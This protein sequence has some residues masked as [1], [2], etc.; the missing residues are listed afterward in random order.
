MNNPKKVIIIGGI[1]NAVNVA[2]QMV[3]SQIRFGTKDEFLGFAFDDET[4][5]PEINGFP[6]LGKSRSIF[7]K[8]EKYSDVYFLYQMYRP[9]RIKERA[10]WIPEFNI[11]TE[12]FYNF[13]HPLATICRSVKMGYG[14]IIHAGCVLNVNVILGNHN[15]INSTCLVAHDTELGN[16]N[17]LAA[18]SVIGSNVKIKNYVFTGLNSTINNQISIAE[19]TMVGMGSVVMKSIIEPNLVVVGNPARVLKENNY[20]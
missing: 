10:L 5:G 6:L 12:R 17:F 7:E 13:I 15:T 11:P 18:H 16:H 4:F 8:Y 1:G 20:V 9:D 2:E 3:D 19:N 14:N